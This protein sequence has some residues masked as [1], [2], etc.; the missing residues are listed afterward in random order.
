MMQSRNPQRPECFDEPFPQLQLHFIDEVQERYEVARPLL[1]GRATTAVEIAQET[2]L[3]PQTVRR[4]VRRF[5]RSGMRGLFD[6]REVLSKGRTLPDVVREEVRR[7]KTLHPP[8][9]YREIA[10]II[11]ARLGCHIDHKAVQ[12]I[13]QTYPPVLQAR[14]PFTASSRYHDYKDPYQARVEV[15]KLYY[16]GWNVQ[17]ISGYLGVSRKHIYALL[18]KFEEETFAGLILQRRGP[19]QPHR[20]LYLPVL[21]KIADLQREYPLLGRYHIWD[22]LKREGIA[23]LGES[24]VGAA[25]AFNR[26]VYAELSRKRIKKPPRLHP[27]KSRSWHDYWFIDHRYLVK[28]DG[29]QYYSLCILEGYSRAFLAG[30]VVATQARGP[31]LKLIY[32]TVRLWGAPV[33]IVSDRGGAFISD[34]YRRTWEQLGVAV[35]YIEKHQSWQNMI[36]THFNIQRKLADHKFEQAQNAAQLQEEHMR[37]LE[38]YNTLEHLAHR[39]RKAGSRTP[40]DVLSW[41]RGRVLT[42]HQLDR[43]FRETLWKRMTNQA[44][45]VVVQNYYLYAERA[46]CRQPVCLWL[47]E[48]SLQLEH[49][50][51]P[52]AS[53]PCTY[54]HEAHT[55][56]K[57]GEPTLHDNRFARQQPQLF[58]L[59]EAQWQRLSQR[60]MA[61]RHRMRVDPTQRKLPGMVTQR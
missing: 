46:L 54:D 4:Y 35:H 51:E 7:L 29:I 16:S 25:M 33:G 22:M 8:L 57:L 26:L 40:R 61:R 11:Y 41:V 24:T 58:R 43:G 44:G 17:S 39:R 48:D 18:K 12:R 15:I 23:N 20:K 38:T 30:L 14:L 52:L 27:F 55:L 6:E 10:T 53:Y 28:I 5:E 19:H 3:H 50:D 2:N 21:K 60:V 36:E 31:V 47:W 42:P 9:H 56:Q 1:L 37:F 34:D 32:D 45:Y 49:Q 59:D 13:L